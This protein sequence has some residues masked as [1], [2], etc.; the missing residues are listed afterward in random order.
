MPILRIAATFGPARGLA[1]WIR[2]FRPSA[3]RRI[4]FSARLLLNSSSGYSMPA[5]RAHDVLTWYASYVN[6]GSA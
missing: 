5:A 6:F 1:M 4:E 3:T 2:F